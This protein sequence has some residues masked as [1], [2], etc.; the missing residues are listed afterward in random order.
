MIVKV[1]I[2]DHDLSP[3]NSDFP[4]GI[5][6]TCYLKD[7]DRAKLDELKRMVEARFDWGAR[8]EMTDDEA[9]AAE[10]FEHDPWSGIE[11]FIAKNFETITIDEEYE[12]KY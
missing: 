3:G 12:I 8:E 7:P 1:V 11:I 2:K 5:L 4:N 10:V 6:E 9:Q